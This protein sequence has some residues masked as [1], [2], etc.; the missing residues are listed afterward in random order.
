[1]K[2]MKVSGKYVR[3][4]NGKKK[5]AKEKDIIGNYRKKGY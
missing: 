5:W 3:Y 4:R 1:M 2:S